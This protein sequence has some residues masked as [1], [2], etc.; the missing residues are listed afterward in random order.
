VP[1]AALLSKAYARERAA[2]ID[3]TRA[4]ANPTPGAPRAA[5]DTVYLATADAD[6]NVVSLINSLYGPFGSGMVVPGTGIAL[7]NRGR[8]FVLERGH[9]NALAPG[10]RPLHT[11]IPAMLFVGGRPRVAFGVMGG[12]VQA[13][14]HVQVVSHLVD[15]GLNIQE[16]L[17]APRFHYLDGARVALEASYPTATRE[18]L[19]ALG[20]VVEEPLAARA[21]GGFGGGQ[22][23][24]IDAATG[25]YWGGSDERKDGGAIGF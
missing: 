19:A 16:A 11:I 8:G 13:Q 12:D 3:P 9:P 24:M 21:R 7:Q 6:G 23:I 2:L 17:D 10:K 1:T 14:A 15:H 22:G 18:R 25:A 20:H 4:L 5:G